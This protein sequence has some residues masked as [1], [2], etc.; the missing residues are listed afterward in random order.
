VVQLDDPRPPRRDQAVFGS[1]E[2]RVQ[3]DQNADGEELEKKGQAPTPG[4]RVL[5]GMS[6]SNY[7][8]V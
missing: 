7:G 3:Q 1:D 2:E 8:P 6:S 4:A 5:G